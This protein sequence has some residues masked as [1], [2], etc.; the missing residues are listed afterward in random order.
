MFCWPERLSWVLS[1]FFWILLKPWT[2]LLFSLSLF[3][4]TLLY[5][6]QRNLLALLWG[7]FLTFP[8]STGSSSQ[9]LLLY[10]LSCPFSVSCIVSSLPSRSLLAISSTPFLLPPATHPKASECV[11]AFSQGSILFSL[12]SFCSDYVPPSKHSGLK[13]TGILSCLWFCGSGIQEG[14][15]WIDT[16]FSSDVSF[17]P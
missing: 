12:T 10:S 4:H 14:F 6:S 15:R 13:E 2:L 7:M 5:A 8:I 17:F 11:L 3:T 16:S 1:I 9:V